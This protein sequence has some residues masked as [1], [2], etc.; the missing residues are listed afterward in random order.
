MAEVTRAVDSPAPEEGEPPQYDAF[1]SYAHRDR[2]VTTAIQKGLH[3]IGRRVGQLRALRVFRDDT[4][5]TANPDLWGKITE[6][7]DCSRFM[8][9]VLSPQSA[10]SHWV[11]EE[12]R[13]WLE[14]RGHEHLMLVLAE[15][16]LHWD[17][18][19]ARFDPEPSNAAPPVLTDPG[20]LPAEPLYIDVG[21]DAP[22]DLRSLVFRDKVTALAAPIHDKPKD[23]LAGDDLREQ[24]RFR[25]LRR[26]AIAGLAVLTV[27][28][29][30]A[31]IIAVTQRQEAIRRLHDAIVAKLN[32][33]GAAMLA[34][35][36]PGSDVRALQ[37]LLA[38]HAIT[39]DGVP[40]LNAQVARFTTQKIIDTSAIP[41]DL[42]YS[43]D[44]SRIVTAE[45]DGT[46]RQWESATGKAIGSPIRGHTGSAHVTFT[47]DGQTIAS[48]G[49]DGTLRLWNADTGNA[50]NT[51]PERVAA[52][53]S[54]AVN[55]VSGTIFTGSQDDTVRGWDPRTGQLRKALRVFSDSSVEISDVTFNRTGNLF[56]ASGN[57]GSVAILDVAAGHLHAP[58]IS[59]LNEYRS[60]VRVRRIAFSPD[61][62]TIAIAAENFLQWWNADSGQIIRTTRVGMGSIAAFSPDGHRLATGRNDGALQL[63]DADSGEQIG[64]TLTTHAGAVWDL[65]FRPDGRQ[66]ATASLDGTLR[67]WSATVGQPMK[68]SD[69]A[70]GEVAFSPD[71]HRVAASGDT[72]VQQWDVD[73]G[74]PLSPIR[75]SG[76]AGKFFGF[77]SSG[78]IVVA[79]SDGTVQVW[80]ADTGEPVG[81]PVHIS[82]QAHTYYAFSPDGREVAS[83]ESEPA[84]VQ[85]WDVTTGRALREVMTVDAA[86]TSVS[87]GL[88]FSPDGHRLLV[89]YSD[90]IRLW[91]I[92][93]NQVDGT[94]MA[95]PESVKGA[96]A[97]AYSRDGNTLAAGRGDGVVELWDPHTG[98]PLAKSP[99]IGHTSMILALAFGPRNLLA[100]G[101]VDDS[102]RIWNTST[103]TPAA[104]PL[105]A[106]DWTMSVALSPDGRLAAS[107]SMDGTV[108]LSPAI[109]D[110][111]QLCDKLTT[112]MSHKQWRDWVSPGIGYITVCPGLPIAPD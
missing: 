23:Q 58:M 51:N 16:A 14:H 66:I 106:S 35:A 24:R 61:G 9:L 90:G 102:M 95:D 87:G 56:A 10:G 77:T 26:A 69:R 71:G 80:D 97:V 27:L 11:N 76:S 103:G 49:R 6:A 78:R 12:V 36:T 62:H 1:L 25:R 43:P 79:A 64:Q 94:V 75:P 38:A 5:L 34:G 47:L 72:A 82:V 37:E 112:N 86:G 110:P 52:L 107:G 74:Q 3:H 4:N 41:L 81:Q 59:V 45:R 21:G 50:L 42:A 44:G 13:Y 101:S 111:S 92:D 109:A 104:A 39:P 73:S 63:W 93:A 68:G 83:A 7:L 46:L 54:I 88:A 17:A 53:T 84:R 29:V 99:L 15:G 55:P 60:P 18:E 40:I 19:N 67:L 65:A 33:E 89:G 96:Y 22:W 8:I 98:K 31:A 91:N 48:A 2:Q 70:I 28:A 108:L 20:S 85:L 105:T 57:N 32:A 30:V 100:S